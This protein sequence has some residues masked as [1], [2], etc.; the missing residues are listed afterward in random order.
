MNFLIGPDQ[1]FLNFKEVFVFNFF[2]SWYCQVIR[3]ESAD[4]GIVTVLRIFHEF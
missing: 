3:F 4:P 1:V 2:K